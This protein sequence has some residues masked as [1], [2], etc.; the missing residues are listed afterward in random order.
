MLHIN[1]PR[2]LVQPTID[3]WSFAWVVEGGTLVAL[4]IQ[5]MLVTNIH[6]AICL[7]H[8]AVNTRRLSCPNVRQEVSFAAAFKNLVQLPMQKFATA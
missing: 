4:R 1:H 7:M 2:E 6:H 8:A 3:A 5:A